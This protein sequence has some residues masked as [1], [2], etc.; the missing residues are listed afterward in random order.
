MLLT[1]LSPKHGSI[2]VLMLFALV[3]L[4]LLNHRPLNN[5]DES[6]YSEI[7][8]EMLRSGDYVTPRFND[9]LFLDKPPLY[10]WLQATAIKL[11]GD[12][13][14]SL[15]FFP[16]LF[17]FIGAL[18]VYHACK[19]LFN[20]DTA[21]LASVI[22]L[23]SPLYFFI[24]LYANLDMEVAVFI[25]NTLLFFAIAEFAPITN[26]QR[27]FYFY[28]AYFNAALGILTKGL[29]GIVLPALSIGVWLILTG[30][31]RKII[32]YKI[33][34]GLCLVILITAPWY[35]LAEK[36]NPGFLHFFFYEQQFSRFV[37]SHFNAHNP[38][39]FY[40]ALIL[41]GTFPW[42]VFSLQALYKALQQTK[43][44]FRLNRPAQPSINT[45]F[46]LTLHAPQ[47]LLY[48]ICWLVSITTFFSLPTS[49]LASYIIPAIPPMA[50]LIA[51][52]LNNDGMRNKLLGQALWT[53]VLISTILLCALLY[54]QGHFNVPQE[55]INLVIMAVSKMT[56]L[57]LI[58]CFITNRNIIHRF[59]AIAGLSFCALLTLSVP[60]W[61]EFVANTKPTIASTQKLAKLIKQQP[62]VPVYTYKSFFYDLPIFLKQPVPVVENWQQKDLE[63]IDSWVG[64]FAWGQ[65][66]E[67]KKNAMLVLPKEFWQKW[68]NKKHKILVL[69]R[70]ENLNDF[71]RYV[72]IAT[73]KRN[74]LISNK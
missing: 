51:Y 15:R 27:S 36:A 43:N 39:Y 44:A 53:M 12:H 31:L 13:N 33:P 41:A 30:N 4:S 10:Y 54:A 57:G 14:G 59:Y 71:K 23:S 73:H 34:T 3:Y 18:S 47:I 6:R 62:K 70:T 17:A 11:F 61:I 16:A 58:C 40:P 45:E 68:R 65:K 52:Y 2:L 56:L 74:S 37:G 22:L 55:G 5:P 48:F 42:S 63:Q 46:E 66:K 32:K 35:Y 19:K 8:Y 64:K 49:K 38:F 69:T 21:Q 25:S 20:H 29:I 72:L 9:V 28:L 24:G 1:K 26:R 60:Q 7:A 67:G 50:I